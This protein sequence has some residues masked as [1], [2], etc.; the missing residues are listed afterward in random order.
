MTTAAGQFLGGDS[1]STSGC[2]GGAAETSRQRA[3]WD[4]FDPHSRAYATLTMGRSARL[5]EALGGTDAT[6]DRRC[7]DCHAPHPTQ[8]LEGV[9][10]ENCHGAGE[11]WLRSHTRQDY[12]HADRLAVG[13]RDL[14]DPYQRAN[15][16]VACHQH[17]APELLQAGHPELIFELDGQLTGMKRHWRA[18]RD[19]PAA[20]NWLVGQ[21]VALRELVGQAHDSNRE[22]RA[23]LEWLLA[24]AGESAGNPDELARRAAAESW[25]A[26]RTRDLLRRLAGT[27]AEF[28]RADVTQLQ[29]AR[30]A[31]RLVLALDRLLA[32]QKSPELETLFALAQSRPDFDPGKFAEALRAL[33]QSLAL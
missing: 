32:G 29:H 11:P 19:R 2:H 28:Q 22:Q 17:V 23:A 5:I 10:C 25:T 4:E 18:E 15:A 6:R 26:D 20:Q 16:C 14:R 30:R 21:A 3:I 24:Q 9:S 12:T 8:R 31:E 33:R 1:C 7:T 27:S 13:M